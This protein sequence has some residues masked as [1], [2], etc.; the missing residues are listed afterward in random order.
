MT[1]ATS[2]EMPPQAAPGAPPE[3]EQ[4]ENQETRPSGLQRVVL[5]MADNKTAWMPWGWMAAADV[6][7]ISAHSAAPNL[8]ETFLAAAGTSVAAAGWAMWRSR[9]ARL[10]RRIKTLKTMRLVQA[11]VKRAVIAGS[12]WELVAS[13]W[14]PVGPH[15]VMQITLAGGGIVIAYPHW[16]RNRKG[17]EPPKP[18]AEITA[19]V[20]D[21]RITKF[22]DQFCRSG[23]LQD[24]HLH[25]LKKIPGGFRF[26]VALAV[27]RRGTFRDIKALE[28]QIAALYRVPFDQVSVEL[29]ESRDSSCGVVTVLTQAKAH[30]REEPWHGR[31]TYDPA[32]GC[33]DL[34]RF[35]DTTASRW[36]LHVPYNG[37][38]GGISVGVI[39]SGKTGTMHV[40]CCEAG[41]A[42]LCA[43]CLT[44]QTCDICNPQRICALL[45]GDPQRQPFGVWRGRADVTAWGP[46]SCVRMLSWMHAALRYRA[47]VFGRMEWDDHLGR[48]NSGKGWFDPTPRF[49]ES[50]GHQGP[51][52]L[53]VIDEWPILVGD[54]VLGPY[55]HEMASDILQEGRKV[56][57]TLLLGETEGDVGVTG[58]RDLQQNLAAY[59]ACVHATDRYAKQQFGLEGNPADLPRGVPGVSFLRGY[60]KRS[61]IVHRT[62]SLPEYLRPGQKGVDVREIAERISRNPIT[63]DQAVLDA[64]VP[65][66]FTGPGQILD[67]EDGWTLDQLLPAE[68]TAEPEQE[69]AGP[70]SA[71]QA[72][73]PVPPHDVAAVRRVLDDRRRVDEYDVMQATGLSGLEAVR[74]LDVLIAQGAATQ[75][76]SGRYVPCG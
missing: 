64:I 19:P 38:C 23:P 37:V 21:G 72:T 15:G 22:R 54:P 50:F 14:T 9:D 39:G 59:N 65:L 56:G 57:V 13:L 27:A 43:E 24:A 17:F 8:F 16:R 36:Q 66:G 67:D 35:A 5:V 40:V 71:P 10:T 12:L 55:A 28:D 1:A 18:V 61:G 30:E 73:A 11:N 29:P 25:G 41:Q 58:S 34:G 33:F 69:A 75:E 74:A 70:Q 51:M 26:E 48:K 32:T 7:A 31:S 44:E 46:L 68:E 52:L 6:A 76:P 42:K 2:P 3:V 53:G 62:K 63:F 20:E 49:V 47:D 4:R 60:D 45:M